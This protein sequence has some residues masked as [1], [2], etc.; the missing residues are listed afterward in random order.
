MPRWWDCVSMKSEVAFVE[1]ATE[2]G[3]RLQ[4]VSTAL[5]IE[6]PTLLWPEIRLCDRLSM[7]P[8]YD[9]IVLHA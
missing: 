8:R 5:D 9:K 7:R 6:T 3:H 2:P 4:V 1:A